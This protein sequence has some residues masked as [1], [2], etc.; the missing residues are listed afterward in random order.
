MERAGG[1]SGPEHWSGIFQIPGR[2]VREMGYGR[3]RLS[4]GVLGGVVVDKEGLEVHGW[5]VEELMNGRSEWDGGTS[6]G[7]EE[8]LAGF[9]RI[10]GV[11]AAL[12]EMKGH[13]P[14]V[15]RG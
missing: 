15:C 7:V 13:G 9:I 12:R 8:R 1:L 10:G 6:A 4:R 14:Q 11:A 2:M 5:S 3:V